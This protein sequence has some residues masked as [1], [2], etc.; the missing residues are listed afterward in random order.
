M[1]RWVARPRVLLRRLP[2]GVVV[3]PARGHG[4]TS[5]LAGTAEELW[6]LLATPHSV[7][8]LASE[9]AARHGADPT[10]VAADLEVAL[11]D[12]LGRDLVET[13]ES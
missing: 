9:L 13:R 3:L 4:P 7:E 5:V 1:T 12:L 11:D 8:E 6:D 2:E 10:L